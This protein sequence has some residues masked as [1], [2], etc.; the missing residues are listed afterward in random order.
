MAEGL[1]QLRALDNG[2]R[3]RVV[4]REGTAGPAVDTAEDLERVRALLAAE[5]ATLKEG[6]P[7]TCPSTSS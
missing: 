5:A 1:E 3:I 4:E 6:V 2:M 7:S